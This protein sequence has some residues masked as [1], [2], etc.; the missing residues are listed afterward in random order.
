MIDFQVLLL[1]YKSLN[2]L[3][4]QYIPDMLTDYKFNRPFTVDHQDQVS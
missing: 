2:G 3:G 4:P 1:I